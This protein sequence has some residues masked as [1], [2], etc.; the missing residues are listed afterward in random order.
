MSQQ[1]RSMTRTIKD[2]LYEA[3]ESLNLDLLIIENALT[4]PMTIPMNIPLGVAL[5][6]LLLETHIDCIVHH[7]D[8]VW[9]RERFLVNAVEDYLSSIFLPRFDHLHHVVINSV[10]GAEFSRRTGLAYRIIP[11][12]MN[13][14]Q[15]LLSPGRLWLRFSKNNW[16]ER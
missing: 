12:V 7:H 9:E 2:R 15:T 10:A 6:E 1:I 13:F 11:N 5:A 8:F 14:D 3:C 4:I 16:I